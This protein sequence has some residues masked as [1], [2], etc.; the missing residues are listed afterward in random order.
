MSDRKHGASRRDF[1]KAAGA[2]A[3]GAGLGTAPTASAQA[4][5][6]ATVAVVQN[7]TIAEAMRDAV[8]LSGG[9]DFIR[10]GQRVL[11]K[12]NATGGVKHPITTN[13][14]VL[15]EMI[16]LVAEA[17]CDD[18][19]VGDR[20]FF[21]IDDVMDVLKRVG[22]FDAAK[23]AESDLGGGLKVTVVP[24]DKAGPYLKEGSSIWRTIHHP[25]ARHY[26]DEAGKPIGYRL[27]EILFQMDHVIN[28]P[29]AKTHF[30]A[31]FTMA[32][33]SFVGMSHPDTRRFFH[34]Y[35][36]TNNL[37]D[38]K[39]PGL[40]EVQPDVTPFTNRIVELNLGFAPSLNV[41]DATRPIVNGGPSNGDSMVADV[42]IASR[43][44]VAA[45]VAGLALLR[46]LGS[47]RRIQT[48]SPWRNPMIRYARRLGI[49]VRRMSELHF[50][51]KNLSFLDE[52]TSNMA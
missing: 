38:Q 37:M 6:T 33:K 45:D 46:T 48:L 25:E 27:A 12:T 28:L 41:I 8:A 40:A 29:C 20:S 43:D 15:Y 50:V 47:E 35:A 7:S 32:L 19:Y 11:I 30:Q 17:G 5:A 44:R 14:E 2:A 22:H 3:V 16:R 26:T 13:P 10:P 52:F 49:G 4:A 9:L 34:G 18:V 42:I 23:Q 24:F 39:S 21:V 36:T 1:L 51:H 31:W